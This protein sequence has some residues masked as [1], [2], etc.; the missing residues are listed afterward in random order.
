MRA[1]VQRVKAARV[2]AGG[3]V[4]GQIGAGLLVLLAVAKSDT[5]RDAEHMADKLVGLRIFPDD[6]GRMNRSVLDTGLAM[7]VVSQ[8]T[9][10][11][12]VSRGRRPGFER[13]AGADL[14]RTLYE[15]F[16]QAVRARGVYVEAGVFQAHMDVH[17]VNDGPVTI[18]VDTEAALPPSAT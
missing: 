10:Y 7:L 5:P 18:I 1:V 17:L 13:A 12:D 9:L 8:F 2:E 14:A 15:Y 3:R 11:G 4:A 16:L 6:A